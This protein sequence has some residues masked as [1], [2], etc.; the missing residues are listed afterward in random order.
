MQEGLSQSRPAAWATEATSADIL[1]AEGDPATRSHIWGNDLSGSYQG[2]GGVGGLL[3]TILE[4]GSAHY[5]VMDG[6]GNIVAYHNAADGTLS[7]EYDYGPFGERLQATGPLHDQFPHR[8]STKYQDP[9]TRLLYYGHRYYNP[10]TGRWLSRDPIGED[11]G[12]NL[13]GFVGN[14]PVNFVDLLGLLRYWEWSEIEEADYEEHLARRYDV[15]VD[16][17]QQPLRRPPFGAATMNGEYFRY[18]PMAATDANMLRAGDDG[19]RLALRQ[20]GQEYGVFLDAETYAALSRE[21]MSNPLNFMWCMGVGVKDTLQTHKNH[22]EDYARYMREGDLVSAQHTAHYLATKSAP[23]II[24]MA[25]GAAVKRHAARGAA[26]MSGTTGGRATAYSGRN[27]ENAVSNATGVPVNRGAGRQIV[28]GT[29]RGGYR[30]PD[31][32]VFG[33]NASLSR[34]G[35]IIEV[36]NVS[37]LTGTKQIRDLAQAAQDIGG[38]L[39]IFTNASIPQKGNLARLIKSGHVVIRQIP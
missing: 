13:Y 15:K 35:S 11:G 19:V 29:G 17:N 2:A 31:M 14:D 26:G 7:A 21:I 9:E 16:R 34:R 39:E 28:P 18:Q 36:K 1:P 37:R 23:E 33:P 30:I 20:M 27:A 8:F 32:Q 6:N 22:W 38:H 24:M 4:D 25:T 3:M 12:L 10:E 5:P